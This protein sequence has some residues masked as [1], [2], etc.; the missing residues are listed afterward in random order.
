MLYFFR[1]FL[2]GLIAL[3]W[4]DDYSSSYQ[5]LVDQVNFQQQEIAHL[6]VKL[7]KLEQK[8]V[9]AKLAD[10]SVVSPLLHLPYAQQMQ[11]QFGDWP[12][13]GQWCVLSLAV[14]I[15][16]LM[17]ELGEAKVEKANLAG[18]QVDNDLSD[19][20]DDDEGYDFLNTAEGLDSQLDLAQA[21][22]EMGDMQAA[23][24]VVD[25]VL[26]SGD[27]QQIKQAEVLLGLIQA[28]TR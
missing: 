10:N 22:I 9:M 16:W 21:Y 12:T 27:M 2:L 20:P 5:N 7:N 6:T 15:L 3:V 25:L 13:S 14:I 4:G 11:R 26:S 1:L 28:E 24:S 17:L 23:R 8:Q 18:Q 19:I